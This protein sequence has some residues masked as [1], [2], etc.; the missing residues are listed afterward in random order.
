MQ[1]HNIAV[2]IVTIAGNHQF[3]KNGFLDGIIKQTIV[4]KIELIVFCIGTQI[5][6]PESYKK[7]LDIKFT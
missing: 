2:S 7:M 6:I 5:L 1:S 4:D 3:V